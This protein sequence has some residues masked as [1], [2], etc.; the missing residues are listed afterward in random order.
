MSVKRKILAAC[1]GFAVIIVLLGGLARQQADQMGRLV[2]AIYDHSFI[3]TL[4]VSRTQEQFLRLVANRDPDVPLSSPA[5]R[6]ELKTVLDQLDV[7]MERASSEHTRAIA[8]EVRAILAA[9]PDAPAA[10]L[11]ERIALADRAIARLVKNYSSD[12]LGAR[13]DADE[14]ALRS[15]HL[16]LIEVA[17]SLCLALGL[18]LLLGHNLSPPLEDLVRSIALLTAGDLG[19]EVAPR[20]SIRRDEIGAVARATSFFRETMQKN[21][22]AGEE[23]VRLEARNELVRLNAERSE[24]AIAAK[25][26]FLATMSHE[27]RTPMNGV[28]TIADLLADTELSQDQLKM[29]N[30]IRQSSKWLIRVINDIL[31]FS[32]LEAHQLHIERV[33]FMLDEVVDGSCQVLAAKAQEK[34]LMLTVEGKDLPG[35]CRIGDPLRLRQILLNL[36]GNAVKFTADGGV[37]LIVEANPSEVVFSV[38]DT[39]IGIPADKIESLFQ[40]YNQVRSDTARS[41]GGTGLGLS[42]TKNLIGLMDGRL[43]VTSES[44]RGSCF[45]VSLGLPSAVSSLCKATSKAV[46]S[47]VR[48]RK[49]D[50]TAAAAQGAVVLCAEDNTINREVLGRVL[51]RLGFNYEMAE[52]GHAALALLDRRRHGAILTDAQMPGLDGWQMTQTIRQQEAEQG[53]SRL[54]IM[55]VTANALSESDGRALAAGIDSVLTKPLDVGEL[56]ASLL[57]AVPILGALRVGADEHPSD[58]PAK[59]PGGEIPSGEIDLEVLVQLVGDDPETLSA[60]LDDFQA[61]VIAQHDQIRAAVA[62]DDPRNL[63]RHAHS[64][65]GAARYAGATHLAQIC[66]L[67]EQR[68]NGSVALDALAEDLASL[69]TAVARLPGEVTAALSRRLTRPRQVIGA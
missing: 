39:G 49:P 40:P 6:A 51:D 26:D 42:I 63:A 19:H 61:G 69:E 4:Y 16:V 35:I 28:A 44:G 58:T 68:A 36:L 43:E 47:H 5:K 25:S 23:R 11:A 38:I 18:G 56:E 14:L 17:V 29:V 41:Y 20:L 15:G 12:G 24:A 32:K 34:G 7:A 50:L 27:I 59:V 8:E 54:P 45:T 37:S 65:K 9:L 3:G 31:D 60:M 10:V 64:I 67:L 52:D 62:A 48:W 53:L 55:M 2:M 1:L 66:D 13:D 30:I 22:A 46:A 57:G 33:P 21:I